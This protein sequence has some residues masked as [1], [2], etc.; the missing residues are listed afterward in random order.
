MHAFTGDGK[1]WLEG[2]SW[3]AHSTEPIEKGQ[4]VVVRDLDGLIIEV[5]PLRDIDQAD[6]RLQS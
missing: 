2:E 6:A 1:V 5:E 4:A 3:A